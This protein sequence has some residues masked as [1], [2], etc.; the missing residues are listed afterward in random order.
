MLFCVYLTSGLSG[1]A[2]ARSGA[3]ESRER[4]GQP[5]IVNLYNFIRNSDFRLRNSEEILFDCTRRQI[6][7][8]RS[9]NLPA[10]WALQYDALINPRYPRLLKEQLAANDEIAAWWEIPQPL[11][12]KAGF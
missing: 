6:E 8:L 11:A 9:V 5:R 4:A 2:T 12:V 10:T 7:L 3:V 1:F